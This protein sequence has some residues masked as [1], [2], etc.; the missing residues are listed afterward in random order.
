MGRAFTG[1]TIQMA[2]QLT[3]TAVSGGDTAWV[4]HYEIHR[5]FSL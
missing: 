2:S 3:V 5:N 4:S 1:Y